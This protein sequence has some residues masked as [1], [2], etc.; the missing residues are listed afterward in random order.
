MYV[1]GQLAWN[2][3]CGVLRAWVAVLV[4]ILSSADIPG[5]YDVTGRARQLGAGTAGFVSV[6]IRLFGTYS[7]FS[8]GG[9]RR[10]TRCRRGRY[11]RVRTVEAEGDVVAQTSTG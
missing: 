2:G 8:L 6:S 3:S 1:G 11:G 9:G 4:E 5:L 7:I 10:A